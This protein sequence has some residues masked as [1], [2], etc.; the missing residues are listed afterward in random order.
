MTNSFQKKL[1]PRIGR[2]VLGLSL[3]YACS[4]P[5]LASATD[6][7][8]EST[9]YILEK[10]AKYDLDDVKPSKNSLSG[11]LVLSGNLTEEDEETFV[12]K[13]GKV[14]FSY[15]PA[16]ISS[17]KT[18]DGWYYVKDSSKSINGVNLD[19]KINK[20]LIL[21]ERSEDG[22]AYNKI[23]EIT[24]AFADEEAY[25]SDVYDIEIDN[26]QQG[27][28]YRVTVAYQV[29]QKVGEGSVLKF[30]KTTENE[31]QK[32]AEV[33][34]FYLRP[35]DVLSAIEE[36]N[37]KVSNEPI[38]SPKVNKGYAGD[39]EIG[40]KDPHYGWKLGYF[41]LTGFTA[42][43][44]ENGTTVVLK[45]V[46]DQVTLGFTLEQNIDQL[47]GDDN[48]TIARD[49]KGYYQ[50]FQTA[51]T[52][53]GRG[54]VYIRKTDETGKK[55]VYPLHYNY[56]ES[57]AKTDAN[58]SV[59]VF[60]EGDYEAVML[61][62]IKKT[63]RKVAGIEVVPE[64]YDY[65]IVFNFK[66]RNGNSMAYPMELETGKELSNNATTSKGFKLDWAKSKYIK[67]QVK[68]EVKSKN[69][70]DVRF[71]RPANVGEEFE[72]AGKYTIT[73]T[74]LDTGAETTKIITVK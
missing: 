11:E 22:K 41:T 38:R 69:G 14:T 21:I 47:N 4:Y 72:D 57:T 1:F 15:T 23:K 74:N 31:E 53:L 35:Q 45:N 61:Y 42:T 49:K 44:E 20:G 54:A 48:L 25:N 29:K 63:P 28:Y 55:E 37:K 32:V 52:D 50:A 19:T 16:A 46:G 59:R 60:E 68:R 40:I 3:V 39:K 73:V 36:E 6:I 33:Y 27:Y 9:D 65:R 64:Y 12:A 26:L 2:F 13:D 8:I 66:V 62:K 10:K 51:K 58:R 70:W 56:L 7:S 5:V 30:V 71:N 18:E 17:E 24:D 43:R 34:D 67:V